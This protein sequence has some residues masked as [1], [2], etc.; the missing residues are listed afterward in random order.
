MPFRMRLRAAIEDGVLWGV[1][2]GLTVAFVLVAVSYV[3]NDY[4]IVR[5]RALNGQ[6]AY[7]WIEQQIAA[8]QKAREQVKP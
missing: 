5:Q 1:K 4:G 3:V 7:E 2:V 6:R 8:Q